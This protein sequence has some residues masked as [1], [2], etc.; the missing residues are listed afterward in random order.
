MR[1]KDSYTKYE[2]VRIIAARALQIAQGSPV[3]VKVPK[4]I[5]DPLEI[6]KLEWEAEVI[7][8]DIKRRYPG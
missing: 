2:K 5:T 7:P 4:G 1:S 3:L 6:A 8:I